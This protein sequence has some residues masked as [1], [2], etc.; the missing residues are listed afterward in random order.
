[1]SIERGVDPRDL[2]LV[3]FGGAGPMHACELAEALGMRIV[4]VPA[5]GGV[6]SALGLALADARRE[7]AASTL[8]AETSAVAAALV[9]LEATARHAM[10]DLTRLDRVAAVR[11]RGQSHEIDVPM[12]SPDADPRSGFEE[13]HET[14]YGYRDEDAEVEVVAVRLAAVAEQPGAGLPS[15]AGAPEGRVVG[16]AVVPLRGATVVVTEGWAGEADARGTLVLRR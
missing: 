10:P 8:G 15:M 12:A 5:A 6:L 14:A 4:L 16:P 13:R 2:A 7:W 1:V 9:E 11:Y 3:A